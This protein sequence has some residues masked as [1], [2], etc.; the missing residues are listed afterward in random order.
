MNN[1]FDSRS[2]KRGPVLSI[3]TYDEREACARKLMSY[4]ALRC[5]SPI[6]FA[7]VN[8]PLRVIEHAELRRYSD[9]MHEIAP[10]A[11]WLGIEKFSV[12]EQNLMIKMQNEIWSLTDYLFQK[13]VLPFM[14]LFAPLPIVRTIEAL[15]AVANKKRLT[16]LEVGPGSGFL[17]AYLLQKGHKYIGIEIT[18]ALYLWQH[19]LLRWLT[20]GDLRE[21]ALED[22]AP[23]QNPVEQTTNV[24]WWYY[25]EMYG[26]PPFDVDVVV[27]DAA[28]GEMDHFAAQYVIRISKSFL[29]NSSIGVFL[30]QN[31]GEP[32]NYGLP[33]VEYLFTEANGYTQT[34]AGPVSIWSA[35]ESA[36]GE[37]L[38]ELTECAPPL[39]EHETGLRTA[40]EFLNLDRSLM[41]ESYEFFDYTTT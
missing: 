9:I 29:K 6:S 38:R 23:S 5:F 28:I 4:P 10:R 27:C 20:N 3:E 12:E 18:Q 19:R 41:L 15:R 25:S 16:V 14:C 35:G 2:D 17:A 37:Y 1:K 21:Y 39:G 40:R 13:P 31:I 8:F 33:E 7:N 24:P 11:H 32:R 30:Y 36:V 22:E 34:K 26:N